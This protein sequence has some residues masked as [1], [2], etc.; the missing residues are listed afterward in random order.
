[1]DVPIGVAD[2]T[3]KII[4]A[5]FRWVAR[6]ILGILGIDSL[7][8]IFPYHHGGI[9]RGLHYGSQRMIRFQSFIKLIVSNQRMALVHTSQQ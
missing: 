3:V 6:P 8:A 9:A 2:R 5:T 7:Q 1:M 4:K